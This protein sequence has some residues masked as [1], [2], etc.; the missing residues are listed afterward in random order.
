MF[1]NTLTAGGKY[2]VQYCGKLKLPT[3]IHLSEKR[4]NFI[5]FLFHFGN[6][7]QILHTWNK[8]IMVIA[9]VFPKFQTVKNFVA[10]LCKK[11]HFGIRLE[12]RHVKMSW[13]L[14]KYPWECF[15]H[16]FSSIEW[17]LIRK[18]SPLGLGE[19]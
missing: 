9:N 8:K 18:I 12:S 17:K 16:V 5:N 11:R 2:L 13:I 10:P 14:A 7:H 3:E 4:K 1:F 19:I 15:Y 6:L